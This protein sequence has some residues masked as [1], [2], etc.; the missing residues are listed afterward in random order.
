MLYNYL[1][2]ALYRC[3]DVARRGEHG[4]LLTGPRLGRP[5]LDGLVQPLPQPLPPVHVWF[6]RSRP[7]AYEHW[8]RHLCCAQ[9]RGGA[10]AGRHGQL[11]ARR[12]R[13]VRGGR[14]SGGPAARAPR[15]RRAERAGPRVHRVPRGARAPAARAALG[16][17]L[18]P[19]ALLA[20]HRQR[21]APLA[22]SFS[23]AFAPA[24]RRTYSN[25]CSRALCSSRSSACWTRYSTASATASL[26]RCAPARRSSRPPPAC[27]SSSLASSSPLACARLLT[28]FVRVL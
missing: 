27:F 10:L 23:P 2:G 16:A 20:Q 4:V 8:K 14:P 5:A 3:A 9:R 22:P 6:T 21:R 15:A 28:S 12:L 13:V 1:Y 24:S 18:L 17:P 26:T 25:A 7:L 19:H 11:G